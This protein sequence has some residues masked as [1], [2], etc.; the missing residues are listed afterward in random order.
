MDLAARFRL[1]NKLSH[2]LWCQ[3]WYSRSRFSVLDFDARDVKLL[4]RNAARIP[5]PRSALVRRCCIL[6]FVVESI[7][8]PR[9]TVSHR[10]CGQ[11]IPSGTGHSVRSVGFDR[12][13]GAIEFNCPS[14]SKLS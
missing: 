14:G 11:D 1:V 7:G 8:D 4:R 2:R 5:D 3:T 13:E 9:Y 6:R 10:E 12:A